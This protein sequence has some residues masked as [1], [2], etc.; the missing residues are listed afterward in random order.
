MQKLI[1]KETN[2]LYNKLTINYD[3]FFYI[4]FLIDKF[5]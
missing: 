4:F 1:I 3:N 5:Y 2:D